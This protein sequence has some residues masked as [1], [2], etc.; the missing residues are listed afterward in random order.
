M[1]LLG[2]Q[3]RIILKNYLILPVNMIYELFY[4]LNLEFS[5]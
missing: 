4:I 1:V 5:K 2:F 3:M